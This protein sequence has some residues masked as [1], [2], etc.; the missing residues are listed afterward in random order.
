MGQTNDAQT[1]GQKPCINSIQSTKT[2]AS[3]TIHTFSS[4]TAAAQHRCNKTA[5][6][7][8]LHLLL[9]LLIRHTD[10]HITSAAQRK[11]LPTRL[12]STWR[13]GKSH[14]PYFMHLCG[15]ALHSRCA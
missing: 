3:A 9:L 4:A 14:V 6:V 7:L 10:I 13:I 15:C 1:A 2:P 5:D 11:E 12:H 8:L